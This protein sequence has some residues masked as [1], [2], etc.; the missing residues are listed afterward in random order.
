M[1][2]HTRNRKPKDKLSRN[3]KY[4]V[5]HFAGQRGC[6]GLR[7]WQPQQQPSGVEAGGPAHL[8]WGCQG[9]DELL[10]PR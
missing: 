8:R 3:I 4:T 9:C 1:M 2:K 6:A 5:I 7:G 10:R